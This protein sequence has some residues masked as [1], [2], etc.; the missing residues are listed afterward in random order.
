MT[1]YRG[2]FIDPNKAA[3]QRHMATVSQ[4]RQ[5]QEATAKQRARARLSPQDRARLEKA[6][7]E[8]ELRAYEETERKNAEFRTRSRAWQQSPDNS[9]PKEED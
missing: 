3:L 2:H 8:Q 5:E 6:D 1:A 7:H 4:L 9:A